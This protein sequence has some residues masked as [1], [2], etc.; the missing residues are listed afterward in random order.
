MA[1]YVYW[2][3]NQALDLHDLLVNEDVLDFNTSDTRIHRG[4]N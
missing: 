3:V 4:R 2:K 1:R